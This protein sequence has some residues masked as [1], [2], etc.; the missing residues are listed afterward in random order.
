MSKFK[1]WLPTLVW[2]ALI[3][4]L[5]SFPTIQAAGVGW[6]DFFLKKTA[7]FIEYFILATLLH[8]SLK[9][10]T[11]LS[12]RA[13]IWLALIITV[14]YAASDEFHQSLVPGREP[15]LRDVIIDAIGA[16]AACYRISRI[17]TTG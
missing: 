11:N 2:M 1:Y 13:A 6:Q 12:T 9:N 7:H 17:T 5:S 16:S 4:T 8:R 15:R 14:A 3:F 10:T